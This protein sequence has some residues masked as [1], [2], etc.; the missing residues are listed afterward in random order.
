MEPF[1]KNSRGEWYVIGQFVLFGLIV[2]GPRTLSGLPPWPPVLAALGIPLGSVLGGAGLLLAGAAVLNLGRNLTP[3]V[4]PRAQATLVTGGA[5]RLVRHP[6]YSGLF[7]AAA[8]FTLI[9]QG[10]LTAAFTFLLLVL[11]DRKS[12]REERLLLQLLPGYADYSKKVK[13]LIPFVY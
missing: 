7:F 5:Y 9:I 11:L 1:W 2:F 12:R 10:W 6:I 3:F 13:R 4:C 8:G